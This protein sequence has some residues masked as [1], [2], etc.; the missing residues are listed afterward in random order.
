M[1]CLNA[2][3]FGKSFVSYQSLHDM[4]PFNVALVRLGGSLPGDTFIIYLGTFS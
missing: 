4:I 2:E 3:M 1:I